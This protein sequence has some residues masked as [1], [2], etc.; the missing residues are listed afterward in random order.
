MLTIMTP[1]YNRA[2]ILPK[3]Y[4]SLREQSRFD[5][6]WIVVDDG[7]QDETERLVRGWAAECTDFPIHYCKQPNGGKHRAVNRGVQL[8][9]GA[10][11]LI[12][13]S[14]D[15]LLPQAVER[16]DAW[17][18]EVAGRDDLA[19]VAGLRGN[20]R[21]V[22]GSRLSEP[23]IEARNSERRRYGLTGDKAEVYRTEVLRHYPFPEFEGENFIR[24]SVVWDR[25][26]CDG[27]RLRWYNEVIYYCDYIADGLTKNTNVETYRKNFQGYTACC[28]VHLAA[29]GG[30]WTL[31]KCGEFHH[32]AKPRGLRRRDEAK[33]LGV[34]RLY[35]AA[36]IAVFQGKT[37]LKRALR[38]EKS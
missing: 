22:I 35:Y 29:Y 38:R 21:G 19:G 2:Y 9:R 5:F 8:A 20:E 30:I 31:H 14:D 37:A 26:A 36:G 15:S 24:E 11:F 33:L 1:T 18:A 23:Y 16:I 32:V 17:T 10:W 28:R 25:I 12:L 34:S 27:Y 4:R 7:S 3:A 13:D 6:E